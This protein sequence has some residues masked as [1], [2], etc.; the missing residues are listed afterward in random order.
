MLSQ[1]VF[2]VSFF[3]ALAFVVWT[4]VNAWLR[5]AHLKAVTDFNLR[6]LDRVGS[7]KDF[8]EFLHTDGGV[9][10]MNSLTAT[11]TPPHGGS[12]SHRILLASQIGIIVTAL[13]I[14]LLIL[15]A[16]LASDEPEAVGFIITGVIS[17]SIGIGFLVSSAVSYWLARALGV[18]DRQA[19][20][21]VL[22]DA[23]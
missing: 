22:R 8:N 1:M 7:I 2:F 11:A 4:L 19:A 5:R 20:D 6:L 15:Q 10:F 23:A 17:L 18:L 21:R 3:S 13:G 16:S 12:P 9:N 14:G